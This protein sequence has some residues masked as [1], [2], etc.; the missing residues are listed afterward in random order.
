MAGDACVSLQRC[1]SRVGERCP[2][3]LVGTS[4]RL[5]E[6]GPVVHVQRWEPGRLEL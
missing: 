4:G 6:V 1:F 2:A 3:A 5:T